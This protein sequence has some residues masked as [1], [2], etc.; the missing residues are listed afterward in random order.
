[1]GNNI[2]KITTKRRQ[3]TI[4]KKLR[5]LERKYENHNIFGSN[6][7]HFSQQQ[8]KNLLE[9]APVNRV[10]RVCN[11]TVILNAIIALTPRK[12][13]QKSSLSTMLA[14]G[15]MRVYGFKK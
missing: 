8:S 3:K 7:A 9:I 2:H 12:V 15:I 4:T 1:M 14:F 11:G 13:Y 5:R 10:T 6:K